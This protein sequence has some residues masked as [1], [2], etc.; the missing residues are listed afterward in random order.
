MRIL[1]LLALAVPSVGFAADWHV[2]PEGMTLDAALA[3]AVDGDTITVEEGDYGLLSVTDGRTLEI[4][5]HGEVSFAGVEIEGLESTVALR[6][7]FIRGEGIDARGGLLALQDVTI[8]DVGDHEAPATAMRVATG[9]IVTGDQITIRGVISPRG[10]VV[11]QPESL[12]EL[13]SVDFSDNESF[14]DG[15]AMLIEGGTVTINGGRFSNNAAHGHGGAMVALGGAIELESLV[16]TENAANR[17]GAISAL[18]G[19]SI[20]GSDFEFVGNEAAAA[21]GHVFINGGDVTV[22]RA[23]IRGGE[24]GQGGAIAVEQGDLSAF[25]VA[26]MN[27]EADT[28][29]GGVYVS[30]GDVRLVHSVLYGNKAAI[31]GGVA[32]DGGK[33]T[34][35]GVMT[36][37]NYGE[38]IAS[39]A[40]FTN[41]RQSLFWNN[42][43]M[44]GETLGVV[45]DPTVLMS[46][47]GFVDPYNGNFALTPDSPALDYGVADASDVDGTPADM[48]FYGGTLAWSLP[49][50]DGDGYVYGRDCNDNDAAIN[51]Q[52]KERWYD[53]IDANCDGLDDYDQDGDG[54]AAAAFGGTDCMD[55][56][57]RIFPGADET[58]DDGIDQNCDGQFNPDE[59]GDGWGSD[60]DCDDTNPNVTPQAQETWYNGID[61]DCSGGSDYDQDGDGFDSA[62]HGGDD[63]D[64]TD[65]FRSPGAAEI[66]DDGID[67]DCNNEDLTA[68][69]ADTAEVI[70]EG[71]EDDEIIDGAM[72]NARYDAAPSESVATGCSTT[73]GPNGAGG[74]ALLAGLMGLALRR[75]D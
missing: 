23:M 26:I 56:D 22:A 74:L 9:A 11:V 30:G 61:E 73:G 62:A 25:N 58:A 60:L 42:E 24:A 52:A 27:A 43:G 3:G 48:G 4:I 37:S 21:G 28:S 29:G 38:G 1:T 64:D 5:G 51:E 34:F 16:F 35:R 40:G 33:V 14:A 15:G 44:S 63:C 18:A 45:L 72:A 75:K 13:A 70:G 46:A 31:G 36:V 50:A 19:A 49:D 2:G 54:F 20:D 7:A 17:G 57:A 32:Q 67:Q 8:E 39:A 10:A 41:I 55:T 59:D 69:T 53:G 68:D 66:A 12:V 71:G 6:G 65:P 47:P